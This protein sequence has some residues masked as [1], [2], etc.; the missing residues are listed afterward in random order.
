MI[1]QYGRWIPDYPGQQYYQDPA[2]VRAYGIQPPQPAQPQQTQGAARTVEVVPA[3]SEKAATDFPV[4]A[5]S[6]KMIVA[7]DDSFIAVKA[8]SMAGQVT[9]DFYDRRPPAPPAPAFDPA[10]YVRRDELPQLIGEA[11]RQERRPQGKKEE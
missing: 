7:R 6:T 4:P 5:G 9:M 8:V 11:L 3:D 2:Y 1:D 10:A